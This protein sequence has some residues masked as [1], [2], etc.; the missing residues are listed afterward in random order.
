MYR[1]FKFPLVSLLQKTRGE[2]ARNYIDH[3]NP[4]AARSMMVCAGRP[5]APRLRPGLACIVVAASGQESV[6]LFA[7]KTAQR[8]EQAAQEPEIAELGHLNRDF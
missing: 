5:V 2:R 1:S 6:V 8:G 3:L 4:K 7:S